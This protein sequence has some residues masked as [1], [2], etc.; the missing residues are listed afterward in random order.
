MTSLP[1]TCLWKPRCTLTSM[2]TSGVPAPDP[3]RL[4][5]TMWDYAPPLIVAAAVE[6]GIFDLLAEQPHTIAEL[7][8]RTGASTR[9]LRALADALVGLSFLEKEAPDRYRLTPESG[10]FLVRGKPGYLGGMFAHQRDLIPGWLH[11][12]ETVRSGRPV[13]AVNQ[14]ES[15][16]FF[17]ELVVSLFPMNL[18]SAQALGGILDV[19]KAEKPLRILD[20]AAGSGVWGIGVAQR[21]PLATVTAVDWPQVLDTTRRFAEQAGMADRFSYI[22]GDLNSV[23]FGN[24]YDIAILG[25]ILHSEG[26]QRSRALLRKTFQAL[27]PGGTIAI[28]EFLVNDDRTGPPIGVIFGLNMLLRTAEGSTY[29]F[30]EIAAWLA[31]AGF[32]EQ[33]RLDP[34]GPASLILARKPARL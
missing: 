25:H 13:D 10:A 7:A 26:E 29:S 1:L 31:E 28:A 12:A 19:A 9:G 14:Q 23:D 21:S 27:L 32:T 24:S 5:R 2:S 18:P 11:L 16:A 30:P 34:G 6:L 17:K 4:L 20:L 15:A 3:E 8:G 33:R 22:G